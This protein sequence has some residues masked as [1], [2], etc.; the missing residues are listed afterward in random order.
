MPRFY[1]LCNMVTRQEK[2][3]KNPIDMPVWNIIPLSI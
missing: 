3:L 1:E 2:L